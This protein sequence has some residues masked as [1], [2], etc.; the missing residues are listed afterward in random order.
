MKIPPGP[1]LELQGT[2]RLES[3][4]EE[5]NKDRL[6]H[7]FL[8]RHVLRLAAWQLLTIA[9][10]WDFAEMPRQFALGLLFRLQ[11]HE[12]SGQ[13]LGGGISKQLLLVLVYLL[14]VLENVARLERL[15]L[16]RLLPLR[17]QREYCTFLAR[18]LFFFNLYCS[19]QASN[20]RPD[21]TPANN[22]YY[23]LAREFQSSCHMLCPDVTFSHACTFD[24]SN[25]RSTCTTSCFEY[26]W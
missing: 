8:W 26:S 17:I 14:A 5:C 22:I 24:R 16:Q 6:A 20:P 21:Q 12:V 4:A 3:S 18:S 1:E 13:L 11:Q 19:V 25:D 2:T 9:R 10:A 23:P 15:L 7:L